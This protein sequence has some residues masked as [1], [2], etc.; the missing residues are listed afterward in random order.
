MSQPWMFVFV[1]LEVCEVASPSVANPLPPQFHVSRMCHACLF[2]LVAGLEAVD[3]AAEAVLPLALSDPPALQR[4]GEALLAACADGAAKV[5][6]GV[7]D[8]CRPGLRSVCKKGQTEGNGMPYA[9][10]RH[11]STFP[12]QPANCCQ[13]R[14]PPRSAGHCASSPDRVGGIS[15]RGC[16]TG[17]TL[18]PRVQPRSQQVCY[19]HARRR[20]CAVNVRAEVAEVR[21]IY[22]HAFVQVC[23]S[24]QAS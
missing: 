2:T 10:S 14:Q 22:V 7:W 17:P 6:T 24:R 19:R 5:S 3:H 15:G 8:R 21:S 1:E 9:W 20:E 4:S 16:L 13:R 23:K 11:V 12:A 18:P